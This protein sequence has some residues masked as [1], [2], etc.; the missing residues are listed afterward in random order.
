MTK[1]QLSYRCE[2][3]QHNGT[4]NMDTK[5]SRSIVCEACHLKMHVDPEKLTLGANGH[6]DKTI[7]H[8]LLQVKEIGAAT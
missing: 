2:A 5:K 3:Q 4:V 7:K 6:T 8:K 1:Y